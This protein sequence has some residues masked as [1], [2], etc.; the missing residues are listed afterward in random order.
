MIESIEQQ[1]LHWYARENG[2]CWKQ[3][4]RDEW[5]R[6]CSQVL[7]EVDGGRLP[8][9]Q[10]LQQLRNSPRFGP[11]GLVTYRLPAGFVFKA[12]R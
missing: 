1:A 9:R 7:M 8:L 5:M 2:R 11:R 3:A 6:A 4:L 10:L 12:R